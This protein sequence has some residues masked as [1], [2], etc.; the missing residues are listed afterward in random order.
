MAEE[1]IL[2]TRQKIP[3]ESINYEVNFGERTEIVEV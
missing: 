3:D 1:R 2:E